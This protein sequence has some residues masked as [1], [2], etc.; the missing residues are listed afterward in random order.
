MIRYRFPGLGLDP[1]SAALC[2]HPA[3]ARLR[4]AGPWRAGR[5]GAGDILLTQVNSGKPDVTDWQPEEPGIDD[6]CFFQLA[7]GADPTKLKVIPHPDAIYAQV[8]KDLR[9]PILSI[10]SC[11]EIIGVDGRSR[12]WAGIYPR[13]VQHL[14]DRIQIEPVPMNDPELL[15]V[16]RLA[17]SSLCPSL[18]DELAHALGLIVYPNGINAVLEAVLA[19]GKPDAAAQGSP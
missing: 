16:V 12:G 8:Q 11:D 7:V 18:T 10:Y 17:L 4:V 6:S 15:R 2:K 13:A 5:N 14:Y 3:L 19:G 1:Q 9:W